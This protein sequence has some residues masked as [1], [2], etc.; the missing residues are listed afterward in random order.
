MRQRTGKSSN[1]DP[2]T[3]L[4]APGRRS[5]VS[6]GWHCQC[7]PACGCAC[8]SLGLVL[9]QLHPHRVLLG[10]PQGVSCRL[11]LWQE[12]LAPTT[13]IQ[14]QPRG[15]SCAGS[16]RTQVCCSHSGGF[17]TLCF[18]GGLGATTPGGSCTRRSRRAG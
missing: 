14:P 11:H 17:S 1:R 10:V 3:L 7:P 13:A 15:F 9:T 2:A 16:G 6:E 4:I 5:R 12:V 18:V 8:L